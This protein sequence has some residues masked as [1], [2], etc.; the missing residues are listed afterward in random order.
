VCA[1]VAIARF[2]RDYQRL[3]VYRC[4]DCRVKFMNPQPSDDY[5]ARYYGEYFP[6]TLLDNRDFMQRRRYDKRQSMELLHRFVSPGRFFS[7]GA[8]DGLEMEVAAEF[9]WSVAGYEVDEPRARRLAERLGAPVYSGD[10]ASLELNGGTYDCV[11]VDQVLEH[12]KQPRVYLEKI[13]QM[14]RP[15]GV[16]YIACPNISSLAHLAKTWL[17]KAG[18]RRRRGRH[19]DMC[20]HLSFY[21]PRSLRLVLQRRFGF[22]VLLCRGQ[23]TGGVKTSG[24]GRGVLDAASASLRRRF[25]LLES[26]FYILARKRAAEVRIRNAA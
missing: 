21:D 14:L 5:L 19:Y 12:P 3:Q 9:G 7:L 18:L 25:P 11:F 24:S 17:G 4:G 1:S 22:E 6:E 23:P 8:G 16:V 10:F 26:S 15:G 2:D 13:R 20:H